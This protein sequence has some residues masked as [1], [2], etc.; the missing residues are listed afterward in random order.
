MDQFSQ[1]TCRP[2]NQEMV[3]PALISSLGI[4]PEDI[5][6]SVENITAIAA[7][8]G[9]SAGRDFALLPFCHTVEAKAMGADIRPPTT[10]PDPGPGLYPER[11]RRT[12]R[13]TFQRPRTRHAC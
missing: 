12:R 7:A 6:A 13:W 9:K 3:S 10:P 1:F 5:Y 2:E 4:A 8:A 11:S